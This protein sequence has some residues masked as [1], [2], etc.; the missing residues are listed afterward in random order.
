MDIAI[1]TFVKGFPDFLIHGGVTLA[2]LM[3]GCIVH[4]TC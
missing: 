1:Q 2:L 3:A 4:V